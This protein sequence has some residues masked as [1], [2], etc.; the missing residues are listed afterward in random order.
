MR[1]TTILQCDIEGSTRLARALGDENWADLL[2]R[3]GH[4]ADALVRRLSAAGEAFRFRRR[5]GIMAHRSCQ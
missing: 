4:I 3:Y 1:V 5:L 2:S